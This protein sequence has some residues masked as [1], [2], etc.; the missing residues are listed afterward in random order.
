MKTLLFLFSTLFFCEIGMAQSPSGLPVIENPGKSDTTSNGEYLAVIQTAAPISKLYIFNLKKMGIEKIATIQG[1]FNTLTFSSSNDEIILSQGND[2][3]RYNWRTE[4]EMTRYKQSHHID[5]HQRLD[6]Y[7]HVLCRFEFSF[8]GFD[9]QTGK[10]YF[11]KDSKGSVNLSHDSKYICHRTDFSSYEVFAAPTGQTIVKGNIDN[12]KLVPNFFSYNE[13]KIIKYQYSPKW[14]WKYLDTRTG[15]QS[16]KAPVDIAEMECTFK[17]KSVYKEGYYVEGKESYVKFYNDFMALHSAAL[18]N[19]YVAIQNS[20]DRKTAI[21]D[22]IKLATDQP[23]VNS[24]VTRKLDLS[25]Q[26]SSGDINFYTKGGVIY[27]GVVFLEDSEYFLALFSG[28]FSLMH[29][30]G[31]L[32]RKYELEGSLS[33]IE[34]NSQMDSICFISDIDNTL[35]YNVMSFDGTIHKSVLLENSTNSWANKTKYTTNRKFI[36]AP[37]VKGKNSVM[38]WDENGKCT[39]TYSKENMS[40]VFVDGNN[41]LVGFT[42]GSVV[43]IDHLG[44]EKERIMLYEQKNNSKCSF[45]AYNPTTKDFFIWSDTRY[46]VNLLTKIAK[47]AEV[48]DFVKYYSTNNGHF[49]FY[50]SNSIVNSGVK[51]FDVKENNQILLNLE[52]KNGKTNVSDIFLSPDGRYLAVYSYSKSWS[53][54][55]FYELSQK[56]DP[57]TKK[58][59][60][61]CHFVYDIPKLQSSLEMVVKNNSYSPDDNYFFISYINGFVLFDKECNF[62]KDWFIRNSNE[63]LSQVDWYDNETLIFGFYLD[64]TTPASL[65]SRDIVKLYDFKKREYI[66]TLRYSNILTPD[67]K[68]VVELHVMDLFSSK[69]SNIVVASVKVGYGSNF[70]NR[71]LLWNGDDNNPKLIDSHSKWIDPVLSNDAR[72]V[73]Y[74]KHGDKNI[75]KYDLTSS[76]TS[77]AFINSVPNSYIKYIA[78]YKNNLFVQ[79]AKNESSDYYYYL[80]SNQTAIQ[81]SITF[82][83]QIKGNH[84]RVSNN[85]FI[86]KTKNDGVILNENGTI[87][88]RLEGASGNIT[89]SGSVKNAYSITGQSL[90]K[91][92]NLQT[93]HYI[94]VAYNNRG[95]WVFYT[96]EGYF[97]GPRNCGEL[98]GLN[99]GVSSFGIDQMATIFNRPDIIWKRMEWGNEDLINHYYKQYQKRIKRLG[100][101]EKTINNTVNLPIAKIISQSSVGNELELNV[102][103]EDKTNVLKSYNIYVNNIPLFGSYGKPLDKKFV[104]ITEK[105]ALNYGQ[106]KIEIG[107]T[108]DKGYESLRAL[109]NIECKVPSSTKDLYFLAFG[110]SKYKNQAYN[111]QYADKDAL[112]LEK[113]FQNMKDKGFANIY[114]KVY[115]NEQVTPEAIKAAKDFVKGAK[116]NDVFV[117]FIAGHGMHEKDA[118]A[119]YYYLTNNADVNNLKATAADFETIEELLQGIPPRNKLFLMDACESGEIDEEDQG[120]MIA[121]ATGAGIA[122]RGFKK[123]TSDK[124]QVTSGKRTYLYQKDR[125]IYYDLA[126]RS[127]SIVFSSSKGGEL[128]Y[129]RSDIENGL[130]TE[131][132]MKALTTTVADKDGNGTISTD[133]LRAYVSEQVAKA[134]GDLQHPTVDRDNI[135]QKFG[136][137]SN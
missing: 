18:N 133:E 67:N 62:Y 97:E 79:L 128:S 89:V 42:D 76:T 137:G 19:Q 102:R 75:Y 93:N 96:K 29:I 88:K 78:N 44:N 50:N 6:S 131:Y 43:S 40:D 126:R 27:T 24:S 51:F 111:L 58:Y 118:E 82:D 31:N 11:S 136:F 80:I 122:S 116:P 30:S 66:R 33:A 61:L 13:G 37:S 65:L 68:G 26:K 9:L 109:T 63:I 112:D 48:P 130:F 15:K 64:G 83:E 94:N 123:A 114:T 134:S 69:S 132:I 77:V 87:S 92:Y 49:E 21:D 53:G 98:V 20:L 55:Q 113:V 101:N 8:V 36:V 90:I 73:Y 81:Q 35:Y 108:S 117:L 10:P 32:L 16:K 1:A 85:V 74:K 34:V 84:V 4:K 104:D 86:S 52:T 71:L 2:L 59:K 57:T 129:E 115:T 12:E 72:F 124:G 107:C 46:R 25:A 38:I 5:Y 70:E 39:C 103:F 47:K 17:E 7:D 3:V 135:Y 22:S 105:I 28:G 125:Y 45:S 100:L 91:Y 54:L 110:V 99:Q 120:Q 106:N 121:A 127:G 41:F 23:L 95:N 60:L 119:T 56:Y 14:N